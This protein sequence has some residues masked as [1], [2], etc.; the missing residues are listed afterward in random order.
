[1]HYKSTGIVVRN[2]SSSGACV[3]TSSA[4]VS[5]SDRERRFIYRLKVCAAI[6]SALGL[7]I[8]DI[9]NHVVYLSCHYR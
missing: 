9:G 3:L 8:F 1:M 4:L 7:L 5:T 6:F 2:N